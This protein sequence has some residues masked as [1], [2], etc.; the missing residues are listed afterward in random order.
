M[1]KTRLTRGEGDRPAWQGAK[2][3][4]VGDTPCATKR[5]KRDGQALAQRGA[6]PPLSCAVRTGL[7]LTK[8]VHHQ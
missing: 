1:G 3:P 4:N 6:A 5:A 8:S 7:A 2:R